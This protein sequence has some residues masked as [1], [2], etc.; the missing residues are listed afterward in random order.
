MITQ[1]PTCVA[2][3]GFFASARAMFVKGASVTMIDSA[4][5][6]FSTNLTNGA[7]NFYV[8]PTEWTPT[9]PI[10]TVVVQGAGQTA[11]MYSQIGWSG[12]CAG[13][14][15]DPAGPASAGHVSIQLDDGGTPP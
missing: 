8:S 15:F 7:G 9:Y 3:E 5:S 12:S 10:K 1:R 14:H 2:I 13:C 4:G 11:T 6:T